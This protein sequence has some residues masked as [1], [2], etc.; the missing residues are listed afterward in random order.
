M[1]FKICHKMNVYLPSRAHLLRKHH[2][3]LLTVI[4]PSK[5]M[6]AMITIAKSPAPNVD[7]ALIFGIDETPGKKQN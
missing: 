6:I 3:I 2:K 7:A 4:I 1:N 5:M